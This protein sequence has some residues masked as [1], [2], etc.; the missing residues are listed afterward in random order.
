[1]KKLKA[2]GDSRLLT[3]ITGMSLLTVGFYRFC[4]P[5]VLFFGGGLILIVIAFVATAMG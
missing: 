5:N 2:L 4:G 3:G 1:M